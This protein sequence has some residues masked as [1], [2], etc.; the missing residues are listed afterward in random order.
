MSVRWKRGLRSDNNVILLCG[1]CVRRGLACELLAKKRILVRPSETRQS[2]GF[3]N[4][5]LLLCIFFAP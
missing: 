1:S 2:A 3:S 5:R 4:G